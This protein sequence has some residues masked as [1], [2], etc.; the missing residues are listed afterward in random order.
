LPSSLS[1]HPSL[2]IPALEAYQLRLT[3]FN[4]T[5]TFARMERPSE[6]GKAKD[7]LAYVEAVAKACKALDHRQCVEC[8]VHR[9]AAT[10]GELEH[11]LRG[12]L[13]GKG[14][15]LHAVGKSVFGGFT[16]ILDRGV[17]AVFGDEGGGGGGGSGG[18]QY[19]QYAPHAQQQFH[20]AYQQNGGGGA[21]AGGYQAQPQP[22]QSQPQP[23]QQSQSQSQREAT[24]SRNPSAHS[25]NPSTDSVD[26]SASRSSAAPKM[27]L[28]RSVSGV[29]GAVMPKPKNQAKL[30]EENTM[31]YDEK[32][33]RWVEPGKEDDVDSGPPP[34]PPT[35]F[36]GGG[37][38]TPQSAPDASGFVGMPLGTPPGGGGGGGG[39]PSPNSFSMCA[40]TSGGV[41]S[42]YVDT[43]SSTSAPV[44]SAPYDA[45]GLLPPGTMPPGL[46]PGAEGASKPTI[47]MMVPDASPIAAVPESP[48]REAAEAGGFDLPDDDAPPARAP[49]RPTPPSDASLAPEPESGEAPPPPPPS[50]SEA[51]PTEADDG[52][53]ATL[54]VADADAVAADDVGGG[55]GGAT[56]TDALADRLARVAPFAPGTGTGPGTGSD[57]DAD[58]DGSPRA[59][60][61][62]SAGST[63]SVPPAAAAA[64]AVSDYREPEPEPSRRQQGEQR[65]SGEGY[66]NAR[67]EWQ[68]G[69]FPGGF[70]DESTGAWKSGFYDSEGV[71][72]E[73][74][75]D[76]EGVWKSGQPPT[77]YW[78]ERGEWTTGAFPG[79]YT[80]A[81]RGWLCGY[82]TEGG[83]FVEGYYSRDG[84]WIA[85]QPEHGG[86]FGDDGVFVANE[87]ASEGATGGEGEMMDVPL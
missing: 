30:G 70:Y 36:G 74:Y 43:F 11:R 35:S 46:L 59:A 42:R 21:H 20:G 62:E 38:A 12:H 77:G 61:P 64:A 39:A 50:A 16:K 87:G 9:L 66:W 13:G 75:Y 56:G 65:Q 8:D 72:T 68:L 5:P 78:N 63:S 57:A 60:G 33:G 10:C 28:W 71:F 73:G 4:S 1:A 18:A 84:S 79:G 67:G 24:H 17:S 54:E 80:D 23:Q 15:V 29:M 26:S 41:R 40:P 27:S 86:T 45:A 49:N 51:D 22:P 7:A 32:L 69:A 31:Y 2:S 37:A 55:G 52:V 48:R 82:F 6:L 19:E 44:A 3:P 47:S 53:L 34:P 14:G 25:R 76:G 83:E 85:G 58:A 81:T